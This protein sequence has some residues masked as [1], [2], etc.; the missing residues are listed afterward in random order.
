M[1]TREFLVIDHVSLGHDIQYLTGTH[2]T[3][4]TVTQRLER[5]PSHRFPEG[6]PLVGVVPDDA[7]GRQ[8][9]ID[10][11]RVYNEVNF[12]IGPEFI[13]HALDDSV[14]I[15]GL[16]GNKNAATANLLSRRKAKSF[17]LRSCDL[18]SFN[19]SG[20]QLPQVKLG[21]PMFLPSHSWFTQGNKLP[22][23]GGRK[24]DKDGGKLHKCRRPY[25]NPPPTPLLQEAPYTYSIRP[26]ICSVTAYGYK[27]WPL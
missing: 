15:A 10:V 11:K 12:A 23:K 5:L 20:R 13:R 19:L 26:Y 2:R 9:K 4:A 18:G 16:L 25:Y 7:A 3:G 6:F 8:D 27:D 17:L 21:D 22:W 24:D 1:F 14:P